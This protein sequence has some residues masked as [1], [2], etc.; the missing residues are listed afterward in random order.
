MGLGLYQSIV[1]WSKKLGGPKRFIALTMASGYLV[2]RTVEVG[3]KTLAKA[4]KKSKKPPLPTYTIHTAASSDDLHFSAGD[5]FHILEQDKDAV[6]IEKIGD[7]NNP[8]FI[9]TQELKNISD[10][11]G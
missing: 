6:L 8:Y 4:A 2:G 5:T 9:S 11:S 3:V 1:V 7:A 10:Y